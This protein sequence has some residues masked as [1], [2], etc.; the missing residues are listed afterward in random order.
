MDGGY[1]P[2]LQLDSAGR[3]K[4]EM[5]TT[6]MNEQTAAGPD[7]VSDRLLVTTSAAANDEMP[8]KTPRRTSTHPYNI[9]V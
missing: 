2:R 4:D 1:P 8:C 5:T 9:D 6:Y 7:P 3:P